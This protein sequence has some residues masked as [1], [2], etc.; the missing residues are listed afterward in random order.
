MP[1]SLTIAGSGIA[2]IAHMTFETI[3]HLKEADKVYYVVADPA[4][5]AFIQANASGPCRDL[6]GLYGADKS[7]YDTYVQMAEVRVCVPQNSIYAADR[8]VARRR[9]WTMSA[10]G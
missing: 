10:S 9:C 6:S 8:R 4:T 1:G 5:E 7:R 2:S 3:A